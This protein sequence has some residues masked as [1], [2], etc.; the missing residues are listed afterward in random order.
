MTNIDYNAK[1]QRELIHYGNNTKTEYEYDRSTFRLT[2][3]KTTRLADQARLQ[4]LSYTYDPTANITRIRDDAQQTI[5]FNNQV[6]T[7]DNDY[8][9]D[10]IYRLINAEG[11][12]HIGQTG[13][14]FNPTDGDYRDYPFVGHQVHSNDGQAMRRY[15]ERYEYDAVGNFERMIHAV[16]NGWTR[17]YDYNEQSLTDPTKKSN[18]LSKTTVGNGFN[19]IEPYTHDAH[20]NMT[21]MPHLPHMDWSFKDQLQHVDLVGGG[22]AYYAYNASGQRVRKVVEKNGGALIEERIYLGGFEVFRRRNSAGSV[23][24]E[25]ETLHIMDD[26]QRIALVE[27]NTVDNGNPISP[28]EPVQRYQFSNH[29]GSAGLELDDQAQIISYEEYYP[30]GNTSYQAGSSG[31]EVSLSG[32]G[33]RRWSGM[34]RAG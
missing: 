5:Y 1:G 26:K 14:Q 28:P 17:T 32:T 8:T 16:T 10:A 15:T 18:R 23:T 20:G 25:R 27:T 7:P 12:E 13:F 21:A 2:D 30:Y 31:A 4:D 3:L 34:R 6:V 33:T 19:Q 22:N 29:L 11:R 9:Y 24:F